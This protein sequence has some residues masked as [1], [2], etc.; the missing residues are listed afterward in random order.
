MPPRIPRRPSPNPRSTELKSKLIMGLAALAI[1]AALS[2]C[3]K[4]ANHH[5]VTQEKHQVQHFA[6]GRWGYEDGGY[7]YYYYVTSPTYYNS[8]TPSQASRGSYYTSPTYSTGGVWQRATT[9]PTKEE[10]E[11]ATTEEVEVQVNANGEPVENAEEVAETNQVEAEAANDNEPQGTEPA[12]A[13][14]EDNGGNGGGAET[15]GGDTGGG[16]G[17]GGGGGGE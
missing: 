2:G 7:W 9:P 3:H 8:P 5:R 4:P 12:G 15:G 14:T 16:G 17:D 1:A 10:L 11:E 6:D 13:A